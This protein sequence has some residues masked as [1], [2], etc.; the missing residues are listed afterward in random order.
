MQKLK[1]YERILADHPEKDD[2]LKYILGILKNDIECDNRL[3]NY[4]KYNLNKLPNQNLDQ[5]KIGVTHFIIHKN[6][7]KS[8]LEN[9]VLRFGEKYGNVLFNNFVDKCITTPENFK[10]RYGDDWEIRWANFKD[11]SA[12]FKLEHYI[13]KYGVD[14]GKIKYN[15]R[16]QKTKEQNNFCYEYWLKLGYT[17]DEAREIL[18]KQADTTSLNSTMLRLGPVLGYIRY[19]EIKTIRQYQ[20][21]LERY[22]AD[23]GVDEGTEIYN[24]ISSK[25]VCEYTTEKYL[26]T[27]KTFENIGR[28]TAKENLDDFKHYKL[29]VER[30]T[31][32][33][34]KQLPPEKQK[35]L[36]RR[37][38]ASKTKN[39]DEVMHV[40]HMVS[41]FFGFHN[42]I[43]PQI[44][45][46]VYNLDVIDASKNI[47][48]NTKNSMDIDELFNN[49]F[50]GI[51]DDC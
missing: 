15:E 8:S 5:F 7:F 48:K 47:S 6:I 32:R 40:D 34:I 49:Y 50:K 9:Y 27:R 44:I 41:K 23:Y 31:K 42:N 20:N 37:G 10:K 29:M 39:Q 35:L 43:L 4:T 51:N 46:S 26:K 22:I 16:L 2:Y 28:W 13:K 19:Q 17:K 12:N 38:P 36:E 11:K 25:K 45:G 21:T 24:N 33:A 30:F 14:L 1:K 3:F 18:S